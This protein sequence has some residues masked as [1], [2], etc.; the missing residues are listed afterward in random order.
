[1]MIHNVALFKYVGANS[2]TGFCLLDLLDG[3]YL[4]HSPGPDWSPIIGTQMDGCTLL[5]EQEGYAGFS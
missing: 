5:Q 1:M 3:L 4:S 2:K